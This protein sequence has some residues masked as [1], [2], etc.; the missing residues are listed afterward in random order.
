MIRIEILEIAN[1]SV[2]AA[3]Y[4]PVPDAIYSPASE[5]QSRTPSGGKLSN[6]EKQL[7]K[8]GKLVEHIIT[9]KINGKGANVVKNELQAMWNSEKNAVKNKYQSDYSYT[10]LTWDGS[11]WS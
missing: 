6:E 3:F 10:G 1:G 2:M 4:Y 9:H 11:S 5:D 7:L 8:D